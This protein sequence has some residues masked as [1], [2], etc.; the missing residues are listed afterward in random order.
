MFLKTS[1]SDQVETLLGESPLLLL[2]VVE[3]VLSGA[4]PPLER[5]PVL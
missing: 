1:R 3:A 4:V 2:H 5:S